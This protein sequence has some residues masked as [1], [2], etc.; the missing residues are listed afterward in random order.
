MKPFE[1][2]MPLLF[3]LFF[4]LISSCSTLPKTIEPPDEKQSCDNTHEIFI[5][6][7][8]WHAGLVIKAKD[9]NDAIPELSVRF[10]D[11]QY[12]EIGWGDSGFYQSTEITTSLTFQAMFWSAGSVLHVV[13][14]DS[15][16][17]ER[18]KKSKVVLLDTDTKH[19]KNLIAFI[20]SSFERDHNHEI[21]PENHGIYDDSQFYKGIGKYHIFNTC[22]NWTAKA[23]YS[24][25]FDISPT[26]KL[27]SS[28]V[29]K[30]IEPVCPADKWV[31]EQLD[32]D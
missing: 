27:T 25:G 10:P 18:F 28:S 9:L 5:I 17:T 13:G 15:N 12:Y 29:M 26:F 30:S 6:N 22:N 4:L 19:Y 1:N 3:L 14:L 2:M 7:H 23:L 32:S 20:S 16:P 11:S 31:S 21:I 8:G 24:A